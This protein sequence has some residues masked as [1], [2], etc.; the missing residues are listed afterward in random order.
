MNHPEPLFDSDEFARKVGNY[1]DRPISAQDVIRA[2]VDILSFDNMVISSRSKGILA[3]QTK[4]LLADGFNPDLVL[5]GAM[6]AFLRGQPAT[7]YLLTEEIQSADAGKHISPREWREQVNSWTAS[8][9][10]KSSL[11][12]LI[13]EVYDRKRGTST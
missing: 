9:K 5:R 10:P 4:E 8:N 11:Q 13:N 7:M 6:A 3:R 12:Q 1:E 2:L